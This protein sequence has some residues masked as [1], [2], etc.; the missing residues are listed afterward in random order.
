MTVGIIDIWKEIWTVW[1]ILHYYMILIEK[2]IVLN[3]WT[4]ETFWFVIWCEM[5][6]HRLI[7]LIFLVIIEVLLQI[8]VLYSILILFLLDVKLFVVAFKFHH[9]FVFLMLI[10]EVSII[11]NVNSHTTWQRSWGQVFKFWW[12][13]KGNNI[14]VIICSQYDI[15]DI[16]GLIFWIIASKIKLIDTS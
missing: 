8:L 14:L 9:D 13:R 6:I 16:L 10:L 1:L 5:I 4:V 7:L 15:L 12:T 2:C 11:T 3:I